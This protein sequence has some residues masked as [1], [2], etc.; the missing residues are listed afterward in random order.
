MPVYM[1]PTNPKSSMHPF[2]GMTMKLF[3]GWPGAEAGDGENKWIGFANAGRWM[4]AVYSPGDA[5][6]LEFHPVSGLTNTYHLKN[7][8]AGP[9][10]GPAKDTWVGFRNFD[11]HMRAIYQ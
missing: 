10:A 2:A 9:E 11:T 1:T 5:M 7:A 8:W 6:P 3:N 4:R